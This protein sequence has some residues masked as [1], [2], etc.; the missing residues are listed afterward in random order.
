MYNPDVIDLIL[1]HCL[2][3]LIGETQAQQTC[4]YFSEIYF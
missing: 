1:K 3:G 2:F 4:V